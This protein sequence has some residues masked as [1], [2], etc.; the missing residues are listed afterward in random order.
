MKKQNTALTMVEILMVIAVIGIISVV[1]VPKF[2]DYRTDAKNTMAASK[3]VEIREALIGNADLR[4]NGKYMK[5]GLIMDI[6]SVPTSLDALVSRGSYPAHDS[7]TNHGWNGPYIKGNLTND[8]GWKI[9]PWGHDIV[10]DRT[11]RTIRSCGANGTCNDADDVIVSAVSIT[12]PLDS[13]A[14]STLSSSSEAVSSTSSSSSLY[15]AA[16]CNVDTDCTDIPVMTSG[17]V[18]CGPDCFEVET[19]TGP[20]SGLAHP[21]IQVAH[22]YCE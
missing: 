5:R 3:M 13:Q 6:G 7:F 14:D 18:L 10:W 4:S 16:A 8:T 15:G 11:S 9:D 2:I 20:A 19:C 17:Y 21:A 12:R 22:T 1:A